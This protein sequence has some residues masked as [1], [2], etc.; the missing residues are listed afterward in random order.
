MSSEGGWGPPLFA[1]GLAAGVV[2]CARI[3]THE[4]P[5]SP[6]APQV[7]VTVPAPV[8]EHV[9]SHPLLAGWPLVVAITVVG[10]VILGVVALW[11]T[12]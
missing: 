10:I 3:R 8:I 9:A 5:P 11:R 6:P 1:V 4:H 7:R 12:R 2:W